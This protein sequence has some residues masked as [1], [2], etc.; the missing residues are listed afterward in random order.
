MQ[1]DVVREGVRNSLSTKVV[2]AGVGAGG[3]DDEVQAPGCGGIA[4]D[5]DLHFVSPRQPTI[6]Q[7]ICTCKVALCFHD[8]LVAAPSRRLSPPLAVYPRHELV[9][10]ETQRC[11][12]ARLR[13]ELHY[14]RRSLT[15]KARFPPYKQAAARPPS[16]EYICCPLRESL[17]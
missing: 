4:F 10:P 13:L 8:Q 11:H 15:A 5:I 12:S 7:V 9:S 2:F 16:R 17:C 3:R 6:R 1:P 14:A